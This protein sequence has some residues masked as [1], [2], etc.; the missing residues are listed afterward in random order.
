[1]KPV[2]EWRRVLKH[3]WSIRLAL[4]AAALSAADAGLALIDGSAI[5]HPVLI[6]IIATAVS[7]AAAGAR[8]INQRK[9]GGRT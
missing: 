6:P 4:L 7:L 1:M 2:P 9:I 3:A 8:L 5:G